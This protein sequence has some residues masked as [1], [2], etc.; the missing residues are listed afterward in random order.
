MIEMAQ[1]PGGLGLGKAQDVNDI[2]D[3]ELFRP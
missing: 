3:A 1:V 2:A